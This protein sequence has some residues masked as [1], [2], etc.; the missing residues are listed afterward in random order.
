MVTGPA[1]GIARAPSRMSRNPMP[2][3][4]TVPAT[5]W[6]A[7]S[8]SIIATALLSL[9]F[10]YWIGVGS[11]LL[12]FSRD[13]SRRQG[14]S[15]R[16]RTNRV[17]SSSTSSEISSGEDSDEAMEVHHEG[18]SEECK[19]VNLDAYETDLLRFWLFARI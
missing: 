8:P 5:T 2:E 13:R 14:R 4:A 3:R 12:P 18:S 10:G 16:S 11:S 9:A 19:L 1:V 17:R 6:P 7:L 15:S